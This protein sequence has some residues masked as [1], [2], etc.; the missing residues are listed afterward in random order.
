MIAQPRE[1]VYLRALEP[2]DLDRTW[3]WHNDPGLYEMLVSP[4]RYVSRAAEGEWIHRKA[5]YSQTEV[6][7]AICLKPDDQHI[8]N[9][10]LRSIDWVSRHAEVG[11]FIGEAQHWSKGYGRQAMGLLLRHAFHD[12]GLRRV[13][14]TVL[15]DNQRAI[16]AYAKCGFT[17]EGRLRRHA[18]KDGQ[19][20]DLIVMGVCAGDPGV[21][22]VQE[23]DAS[24]AFDCR[25]G[26]P[27]V[28]ESYD[29][30]SL[31]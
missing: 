1:D 31:I 9:I 27:H 3:K 10:H 20:R 4:F 13:Y 8:G 15:E 11:V 6:Q 30:A 25:P 28:E 24:E 26:K 23:T 5:A 14:L 29:R 16:R 19:Y 17:V 12:L 2:S 21:E 18:Y 22:R 7:L